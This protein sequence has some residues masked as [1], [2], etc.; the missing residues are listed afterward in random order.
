M[1]GVG[2]RGPGHK[3]VAGPD[4]QMIRGEGG[5][6]PDPDIRGG[7]LQ[8]NFFSALR[9]SVWSKEFGGSPGS[10]TLSLS[11]TE[12]KDGSTDSHYLG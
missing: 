3:P 7:S 8:K 4:L 6:H 2:R 11:C 1:V 5:G 9:A 12:G 10:A